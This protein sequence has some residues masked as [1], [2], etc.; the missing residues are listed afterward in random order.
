MDGDLEL[1]KYHDGEVVVYLYRCFRVCAKVGCGDFLCFSLKMTGGVMAIV[2][3][4]EVCDVEQR[5]FVAAS[6]DHELRRTTLTD[7]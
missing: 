5:M 3:F 6:R 7:D 1:E 4:L 2:N